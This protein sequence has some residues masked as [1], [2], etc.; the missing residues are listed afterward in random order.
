[1]RRSFIS[2]YETADVPPE[3]A[4]Q[5]RKNVPLNTI[6][7]CSKSNDLPGSLT[8]G[9]KLSAD[10][11]QGFFKL[12]VVHVYVLSWQA[13]TLHCQLRQLT[14]HCK[15]VQTRWFLQ[16][17]RGR[18]RGDGCWRDAGA[19]WRH[20]RPPTNITF[21]ACT[22]STACGN[23]PGSHRVVASFVFSCLLSFL[24][25]LARHCPHSRSRNATAF[26]WGAAGRRPSLAEA[27]DAARWGWHV[28]LVRSRPIRSHCCCRRC[29]HDRLF[30]GAV[31]RHRSARPC[32]RHQG[33]SEA[34][35]E[36]V[37][38][39]PPREARGGER[40]PLRNQRVLPAASP[41]PPAVRRP[42]VERAAELPARTA[43]ARVVVRRLKS[44]YAPS[45]LFCQRLGGTCVFLTRPVVMVLLLRR[46]QSPSHSTCACA[47]RQPAIPS[48]HTAHTQGRD[49]WNTTRSRSAQA[50]LTWRRSASPSFELFSASSS[51]AYPRGAAHDVQNVVRE[52]RSLDGVCLFS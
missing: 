15:N 42:A 38:G 4:A 22:R 34:H 40:R 31:Q 12:P 43:H 21:R 23:T 45:C 35:P 32:N 1:M 13:K 27:V 28:E 48:T 2:P 49:R 7:V 3:L 29:N 30:R 33:K 17:C 52:A 39:P 47:R 11:V 51:A 10:R 36:G 24:A 25:L 20:R 5:A 37:C 8:G 19:T 14:S 9:R 6:P 18:Q 16:E 46:Q 50:S 26:L 44:R 41:R